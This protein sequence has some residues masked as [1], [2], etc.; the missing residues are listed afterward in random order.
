MIAAGVILVAGA[1]A[2]GADESAAPLPKPLE[3]VVSETTPL[4]WPRGKRLPL[5]LWAA[6]APAAMDDATAER[7]V[8]ALNERGVA[9]VTSWEPAHRE[10]SLEAALRVARVQTRLGVPVSVNATACLSSFYDGTEGTAHIDDAGKPFWDTSFGHTKMGCPFTLEPRR[11]PLRERVESFAKAYKDAGVNLDLVFA[12]WEIDGPT[13]F[14]GAHEASKRCRRCRERVRNI[15][16]FAAFQKA[17]RTLRSEVQRDVFSRPILDRYPRALVGN[18][19]VYPHNGLRYWYDYFEH[20]V[21]GQPAVVDQRARYRKWYPEFA[22][23]GYTMAMPVVYTWYDTF[24]WYDFDEPDYRWFYNL[25]LVAS[26][27]GKSTPADVP[28]VAFVHWHTVAGPDKPDPGVKQFSEEKYQELLWHML[29]RGVD[30]F[31]MWSPADEAAKETRLVH[32]VYAAAQQYGE[33]LERG[34]PVC[35][36]VPKTPAPVVSGLRLG[37]RVLVRRTEFGHDDRPITLKVGDAA[38]R[39]PPAPGRMQILKLDKQR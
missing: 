31:F 22:G 26:N 16:D 8:R 2:A 30:T 18:Y 11:A 36:D 24:G 37:D 17:M 35:F 19:A 12:D 28:I 15:D 4:R 34:E 38:L 6:H 5:Y 33:F 20:Y 25:L 13:E 32:G 10:R 23:T 9:L 29:L 14:N 27:A 1:M 7:A 21:D 39:V 3:M